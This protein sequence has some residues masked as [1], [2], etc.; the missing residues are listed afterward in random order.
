MSKPKVA[1]VV[2]LPVVGLA[3]LLP[4]GGHLLLKKH[5]RGLLLMGAVVI[6]YLAGLMMRGALFSPQTGD[7]FTTLIYTGGFIGN[8][9]SGILYLLTVWLGYA[10]PDVAGHVHDYGTK[11]L[12]G[13]GLMNVLAIV[14]A[15]ELA[16]GKKS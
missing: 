15:Y 14:D 10:Q 11:F 16:V 9:A 5:A 3:W 13:A 7:L 8:L 1:P 12:V 2:W 4:G 6:A